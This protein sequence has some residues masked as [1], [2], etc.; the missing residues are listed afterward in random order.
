ME[1]GMR[2]IG[3]GEGGGGGERGGKGEEG[4]GEGGEGGEGRG[5]E[6]KCVKDSDADG[7]GALNGIRHRLTETRS[8]L[9]HSQH[10]MRET[11]TVVAKPVRYLHRYPHLTPP[12]FAKLSCANTSPNTLRLR[13]RLPLTTPIPR[14]SQKQPPPLK[15]PPPP[16]SAPTP[17][18]PSDS[19]PPPRR[20]SLRSGTP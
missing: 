6:D 17:P 8:P 19:R 18:A 9:Q 1:N 4:E 13:L 5:E 15:P 3:W 10:S 2:M 11:M 7:D 12:F 14:P 20:P 16:P